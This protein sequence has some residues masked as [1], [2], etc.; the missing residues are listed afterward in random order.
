MTTPARILLVE[1]DETI[2]LSVA[3]ALAA[4][5]Y[6]VASREDGRE[7]PHDLASFVPDLLLLDWMLPGPSGIALAATARQSSG[8]AVM[9]LTARDEVDDRLRGFAEGIDDYL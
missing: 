8:C 3:A 6:V 9:M 7:L 2:R 5:G 4:E 1:D